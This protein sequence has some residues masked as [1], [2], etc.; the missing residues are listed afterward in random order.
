L[1]FYDDINKPYQNVGSFTNRKGIRVSMG[2]D[3]DTSTTVVPLVRIA[4]RYPVGSVK[5]HIEGCV[6]VQ[7]AITKKDKVDDE[8][9]DSNQKTFL[10]GLI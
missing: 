1:I 3:E 7:F 2:I 8:V 5:Q 9:V 4:L 6:K 10:T